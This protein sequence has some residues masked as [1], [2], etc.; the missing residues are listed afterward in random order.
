MDRYSEFVSRQEDKVDRTRE[1]ARFSR[2][3]RWWAASL[4]FATLLFTIVL[5]VGELT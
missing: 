5:V 2:R 4:I 1:L 3:L